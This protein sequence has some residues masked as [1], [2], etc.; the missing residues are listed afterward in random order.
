MNPD[1]SNNSQKA[2]LHSVHVATPNQSCIHCKNKHFIFQCESFR[3]L[4]VEKRIEII[5]NAHL[6]INCL[7]SGNHQAKNCTAS[8][9]RKC[10]KPHNTLLHFGSSKTD[11]SMN[12]NQSAIPPSESIQASSSNSSAPLV[13]QCSQIDSA[14]KIF[15]SIALIDVYN[16]E[17]E[18]HGC[19]V[20]L[21]SGSQLNF[22]T[23]DFVNKLQL[24]NRSLHVSISG[25]AEGTFES[26]VIIDV[27]F[28]SRVNAYTNNIE[29][30]VLPKITQ[31][32]PQKFYPVSEFKIP[33]NIAL[34]DPNFNIPGDVDLLIGAQL[35]WQLIC[36]GQIRACKAHPTL[37]KTKLG[38]V[39][40]GMAHG[41]S[42]RETP[43]LCHL[44]TAN[45]LDK[46]ISRFWEVEHDVSLNNAS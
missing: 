5:R 46:S 27:S 12:D 1:L 13:T 40:S 44:T 24:N 21:N 11:G 45:E 32:L 29:C 36:V 28:R 35:F 39:I 37:Q 38:W 18:I 20:L 30:I 26:K 14:S 9:C 33:S 2:K 16:Y 17:G 25:V 8:L 7:R 23:E 43:V 19:R 6:C 31:K 22:I 10:G 34:A 4:P 15:L 42:K 3:K 41:S